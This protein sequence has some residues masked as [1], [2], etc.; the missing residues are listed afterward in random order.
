VEA[1]QRELRDHV[2][3]LLENFPTGAALTHDG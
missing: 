3:P 2:R 1:I